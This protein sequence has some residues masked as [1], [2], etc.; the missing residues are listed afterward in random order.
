MKKNE[1]TI[2]CLGAFGDIINST[3]IAKHYKMSGKFVRWIVRK[4]YKS[5]LDD[6]EFI[7]EIKTI[8]NERLDNSILSHKFRSSYF[9]S[10][11]EKVIF[12]APYMSLL[13]D[14]THRSSLLK[15]IK[16]ETSLINNWNCDFI[17]IIRLDHREESEARNFFTNLP[18]GKKVLVEFEA[19]SRQT[20]M[21]KELFIQMVSK[22][23]KDINFIFSSV[24]KPD[25]W[26]EI[27]N[28]NN[29]F[30]YSGSFKSNAKLYNLCDAFVG[31]SSGITCLTSSDYC[32]SDKIRIEN[33]F[34]DHWS[35]SFWT[36]NSKNKKLCYN[37]KQFLFALEEM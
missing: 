13:Y 9:P 6:N 29:V 24:N 7:D 37:A 20:F 17:P 34:G 8:T 28:L 21:T 14:G 1:I 15:I 31:C 4:K 19:F 10:S 2:V 22:K 32:Q 18:E 30:H 12:T 16:E 27:S 25:W 23:R 33:C 11:C 3:P 35:T 36:H 26:S 5:V